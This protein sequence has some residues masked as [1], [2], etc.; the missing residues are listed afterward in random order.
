MRPVSVP[1][2]GRRKVE[3][4]LPDLPMSGR[5]LFMVMHVIHG[6]RM[7]MVESTTR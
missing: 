4:K 5:P 6:C 1:L 2:A 7:S 3:K